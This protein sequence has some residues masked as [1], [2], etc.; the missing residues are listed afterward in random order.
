[1]RLWSWVLKSVVVIGSSV[2]KVGSRR[3]TQ[4]KS[5]RAVRHGLVARCSCL[6]SG[7]YLFAAPGFHFRRALRGLSQSMQ[8]LRE[9]AMTSRMLSAKTSRSDR[10]DDRQ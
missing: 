10:R 5:R 7:A 8:E 2:F 3:V 4:L 9:G 6:A 1:M